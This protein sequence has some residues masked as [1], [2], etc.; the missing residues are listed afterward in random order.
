MDEPHVITTEWVDAPDDI[1]YRDYVAGT[2]NTFRCTCAAPLKDR[3]AATLHA[4]EWGR[5]VVCLGSGTVSIAPFHSDGCDSCAGSGAGRPGAVVV[6]AQV[7]EDFV[8]E[9]AELLPG[10]FGLPD[11]VAVLQEHMPPECGSMETVFSVAAGLIRYLEVQGLVVL[12]TAPDFVPGEG[13]EQRY[14]DPRWI[15]TS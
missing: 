1:S 8:R 4:A 2:Y 7:T 9:V 15:R 13:V 6:Q 10:E 12:A 11:V 5:C 3:E 14:G